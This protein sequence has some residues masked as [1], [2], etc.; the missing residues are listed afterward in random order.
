MRSALLLAGLGWYLGLT[1]HPW[2]A[3]I[4]FA[5]SAAW[6]LADL[7]RSAAADLNAGIA[8]VLDE[9]CGYWD[10]PQGADAADFRAWDL[11]MAQFDQR[12]VWP[13]GDA[14]E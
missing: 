10:T 14:P 6:A 3:V 13:M 7:F 12:A 2:W 9:D 8:A 4:A 5:G 1:G 11:E